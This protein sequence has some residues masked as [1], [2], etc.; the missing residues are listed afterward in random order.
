MENERIKLNNEEWTKINDHLETEIVCMLE[1]QKECEND[2]NMQTQFS[3]QAEFL[4]MKLKK[5]KDTIRV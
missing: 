2:K 5:E 1:I 3:N 4:M